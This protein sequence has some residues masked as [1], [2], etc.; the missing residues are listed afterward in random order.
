MKLPL[1]PAFSGLISNILSRAGGQLLYEQLEEAAKSAEE[2]FDLAGVHE[3]HRIGTKHSKVFALR[4]DSYSF[5]IER[6]EGGIW[7]LTSVV[8][9]SQQEVEIC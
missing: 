3:K 5:T 1:T 4:S 6:G 2:R 9:E 8:Q 7:A